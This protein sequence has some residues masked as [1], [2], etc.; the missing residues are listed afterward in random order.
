M[1]EQKRGQEGKQ[2]FFDPGKQIILPSSN[3]LELGCQIVMPT[4]EPQS[5]LKQESSIC[6]KT[7]KQVTRKENL[8]VENLLPPPP[9]PPHAG[10]VVGM[11]RYITMGLDSY[12]LFCSLSNPQHVTLQ[13]Y[14]SHPSFSYFPLF[15]PHP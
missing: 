11:R 4:K 13:K 10:I 1:W 8:K 3:T 12:V 2:I 6:C 9:P 7:N 15:Q 5:N 14:F